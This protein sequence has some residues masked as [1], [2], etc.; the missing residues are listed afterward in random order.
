MQEGGAAW[1]LPCP[2]D[3]AISSE[4]ASDVASLTFGNEISRWTTTTLSQSH[5]RSLRLRVSKLWQLQPSAQLDAT[6]FFQAAGSLLLLSIV[7]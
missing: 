5:T 6:R 4:E 1:D 7:P 3:P 2:Q